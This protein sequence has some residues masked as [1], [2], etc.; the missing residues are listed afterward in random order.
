MGIIIGLLIGYLFAK[1]VYDQHLTHERRQA[2]RQSKSVI[3]GYNQEKMAPLAV[4][5]PYHIKDMVFVGKWVDYIVFDGLSC[6]ALQQ[7]VF[8]EIKSWS[9]TQNANEVAIQRVIDAKK[10]FYK[11]I[12]R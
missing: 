6:G 7:V 5:F 3:S 12:K 4:D 1:N 10:V 11:I 9:S 8:L 2:V